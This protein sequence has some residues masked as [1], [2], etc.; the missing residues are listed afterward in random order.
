MKDVSLSTDGNA[1]MTYTEREP[2]YL[3]YR[4]MYLRIK[5]NSSVYYDGIS[6]YRQFTFYRHSTMQRTRYGREIYRE[7]SCR[8]MAMPDIARPANKEV[9][10][11]FH[12]GN[13]YRIA[14]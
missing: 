3:Y 12:A 11:I 4:G 9:T 2:V 5:I 1:V 14:Q 13:L 8:S 6:D 7:F 10:K